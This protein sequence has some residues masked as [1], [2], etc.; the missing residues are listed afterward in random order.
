MIQPPV[1]P[2]EWLGDRI[3][4]IDQ[5]KLPAE[6]VYLELSSAN[7]V[8]SAIKNMALRGA[9]LIGVVAAMGV[10][11]EAKRLFA[12]GTRNFKDGLAAALETL[13]K[14]RPT[15][16]NL[17]WA[18]DRMADVVNST[19]SL[20]ICVERLESAALRIF[21][22]DLEAGNRMGEVGSELIKEGSTLLTHCNAGGLATS[23]FGTALAPMYVAHAR[24][25]RFRVF[26][27]E[28]R[29]L[30]QG[31]RLTAWELKRSGIDVTV[32]CDSAAHGLLR[33]GVIDAVFVG[34]DRIT[35][36]GDFAN[37]VGTYG[38]AVCA[39]VNRVPFY[40]VAPT[41]TIDTDLES[42]DEI[43]I[44]ERDASEIRQIGDLKIVPNG[45]KVYNP[46]FDVTPHQLVTGF[47]TENGLVFPPFT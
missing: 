2:V 19:D 27:D 13:R 39:N 44:E 40:V 30:L 25:K 8:A 14:T 9:P 12:L 41:S 23:G 5:R 38:L 35:R 6:E 31:A 7:E 46:A 24:G 18:L 26:A 29:P 36:S 1:K 11:V 21:D 3:R 34:A 20:E 45:V 28:T 42:G 43:P 33:K 10:A 17:F 47:I 15:A 4:I 16:S 22:E 32:I 37:K